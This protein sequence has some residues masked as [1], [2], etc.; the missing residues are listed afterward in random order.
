MNHIV[1]PDLHL[2]SIETQIAE[3]RAKL[4]S[5]R[6]ARRK[7]VNPRKSVEQEQREEALRHAYAFQQIITFG[8]PVRDVAD[9]LGISPQAV[10]IRAFRLGADINPDLPEAKVARMIGGTY[11]NF[12]EARALAHE[13]GLTVA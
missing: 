5:L 4:K 13:L 7:L 11:R 2:R 8:K 6:A 10:L 9:E 1:D 3:T 12:Q